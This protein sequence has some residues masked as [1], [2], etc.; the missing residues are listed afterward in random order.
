MY[1]VTWRDDAGKELGQVLAG[2]RR[3]AEQKIRAAVARDLS[4]SGGAYELD[5]PDD[6]R[7]GL[8]AFIDREMASSAAMV[9]ATLDP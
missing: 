1:R 5:C 2:D 3:Q 6:E 4:G 8:V 9:P 7:T